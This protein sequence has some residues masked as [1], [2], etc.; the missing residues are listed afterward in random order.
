MTCKIACT[1]PL[2]KMMPPSL[3]ELV[4]DGAFGNA[5]KFTG[6]I[7]AEWGSLTNLKKLSMPHCGLDG[8]SRGTTNYAAQKP[9]ATEPKFCMELT[10]TS[11]AFSHRRSTA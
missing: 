8:A 5:H 10:I 3:E 6:G 7:P 4:L 2:P 1:G 11:P 9:I